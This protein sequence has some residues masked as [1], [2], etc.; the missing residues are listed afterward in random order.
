M[1][2]MTITAGLTALL[3][4][5]CCAPVSA[6]DTEIPM[7]PVFGDHTDLDPLYMY[8]VYGSA[9]L[10]GSKKLPEDGSCY[11]T[12]QIFIP[13]EYRLSVLTDEMQLMR[14]YSDWSWG[15]FYWR[16]KTPL[17]VSEATQL[18][19][20]IT[21]LYAERGTELPYEP[22]LVYCVRMPCTVPG[23][24]DYNDTVTVTDAKKLLDCVVYASVAYSLNP[25]EQT[26][27]KHQYP[28]AN[29]NGDGFIDTTD[30]KAIL[31]YAV[32][33]TTFGTNP[34]WST[35]CG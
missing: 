17:S 27:L 32:Y 26:M 3:T 29:V 35:I 1:K 25:G 11:F 24:V 2:Q 4:A 8:Y 22:T 19:S 13:G 20:E 14:M 7:Y 31:D 5:L 30:V 6:A 16:E 18:C 28:T 9:L 10:D 33:T 12:G 21:D 23:D 34:E 15:D